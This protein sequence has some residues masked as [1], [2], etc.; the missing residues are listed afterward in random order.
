MKY[1]IT[2]HTQGI[3][4]R[5][6]ERLQPDCIG[7]SKSSGYDITSRQDRKRI[8]KEVEDSDVFI[9]NACDEFGQTDILIDFFEMYRDTDK[10]IINVGSSI[11]ETILPRNHQHLIDYQAHKQSL[12]ATSR[13]LFNTMPDLRIKYVW[14]G[15]VGTEKILEKYPNLKEYISVDEACDRILKCMN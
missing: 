14:F 11:A 1:A 5:L 3:G 2:G 8:I 9:N 10:T 4:K 15:Y 12:K 6:Y 7:F 13:D